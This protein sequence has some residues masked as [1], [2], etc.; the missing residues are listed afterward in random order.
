M[1]LPSSPWF[2]AFALGTVEAMWL[3]EINL[4]SMS[5][6]YTGDIYVKIYLEP[7][8]QNINRN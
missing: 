5:E 4:I 6:T 2:W 7:K 3:S 1:Q 8:K